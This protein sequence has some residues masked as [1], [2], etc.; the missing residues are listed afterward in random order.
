M[1][2]S[3]MGPDPPPPPR[4]GKN[5]TSETRPFFSILCKSVFSPLKTEL[6]RMIRIIQYSN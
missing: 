5:K 6:D 4:Y 2:N 3:M 1:E